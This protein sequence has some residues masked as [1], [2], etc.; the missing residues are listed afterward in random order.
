MISQ[1]SRAF[2]LRPNVDLI[3]QGHRA[4]I[5]ATRLEERSTMAPV[6]SLSFLIQKLPICGKN[7]FYQ[8]HSY[9]ALLRRI[10]YTEKF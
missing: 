4:Y 7:N 1:S 6:M 8:K 10:F 3:F 9:K 2:D 5:E